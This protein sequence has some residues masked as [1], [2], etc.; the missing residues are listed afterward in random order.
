M[1]LTK[2]SYSMIQGAAYNVLD[3]GADN[4]GAVSSVAAFNSALLLGGT[5]YVPSGTYKLD[6][7][8]SLTVN[9]T[10][11]WLAANVTLNLS[12]VPATQVPFGNQI[13]VIASNCAVIGSGPSSLLQI[14]GGSQA[15]AVG[16]LHTAPGFT[17]RDLTIDGDKANGTTISDDTFMSGISILCGAYGG[18]TTDVQA[19]VDNCVIKNFLQYGV[20]VYGDQ[21]NGVK[22]VNCNIRDIG[23]AGDALS[24]GGGIVVTR[25]VSDFI[26]SNNVIKNCKLDG[27][28]LSSA[29]LDCGNWTITGNV[30]HQN[31]GSGITFKESSAY[32]SENNIG[33]F[34]IAVTGNT[35]TGNT[36]SGI[37]LNVDT[38]GYLK[39][40]SITGNT[41]EG[42]TFSGIEVSCTNTTPNIISGIQISGNLV[43]DNGSFQITIGQYVEAVQGVPQSFT[44][45][46]KGSTTA[47]VGTYTS[48]SGLYTYSN[49]IVY[50]EL[51]LDWSAHTG[52]GDILIAGFPYAGKNA[53]PQSTS[54]VWANALT[55]TGQGVFSPTINA[56]QGP[57]GAINNGNYSAVALDTAATLRITGFYFTN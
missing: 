18:A 35:S 56:T 34:N 32:S 13:H 17:I 5:V 30:C 43:L 2:V 4:T 46:I 1:A 9:N 16:I 25:G 15:N 31:G 10:T 11:L 36:R 48:Q 26:A 12:G 38:V 19:T 28:F 39:Y 21:A 57:L 6:S 3:F 7:K 51:V 50:F 42:N 20:S 23:K 40:F 47:G 45:V 44:P 53:E 8:V 49:G 41:C 22:I 52:S 33:L 54:W 29:G 55:I 24:V 37:Q 27:M 14:T